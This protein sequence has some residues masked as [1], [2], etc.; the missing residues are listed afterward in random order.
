M[1]AGRK[2]F[3][4]TRCCPESRMTRFWKAP[5]ARHVI[6]FWGQR[7][8]CVFEL[9]LSQRGQARL[10]DHE[11]IADDFRLLRR[12]S[13]KTS[14]DQDEG[15]L[16]LGRRACPRSFA[17]TQGLEIESGGAAYRKLPGFCLALDDNECDVVSRLSALR[18]FG[19]RRLDAI[20]NS[21]CRSIDVS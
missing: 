5:K 20:A 17:S 3:L 11:V 4:A 7:P 12:K 13:F 1:R 19:Q 9:Y 6:A 14:T 21:G 15:S 8:R 10:P 2:H 16:R 18:E